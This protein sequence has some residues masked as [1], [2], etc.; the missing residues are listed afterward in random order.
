[1]LKRL[2]ETL[3][4]PPL[5]LFLLIGAGLLLCR[6]KPMLGKWVAGLSALALWCLCT[7]FVAAALLRSLQSD[8]AL[9]DPGAFEAQAIVVFL[10]DYR[11]DAAEY[12]GDSVGPLTL[13]RLRY[14]A[15]LS[16]G[17]GLPVLTSGGRPRSGAP[18]LASMASEVLE[19]EFGVTA[20]WSE[21]RAAN[22]RENA[23]FSAELLAAE[24]I[25]RV[26]LVTHAWHM[27]RSKGA[28]ARAGLT[29]FPAPTGFRAWPPLELSAFVPSARS[30]R[31]SSWALHEWVG[32]LWYA[33]L[34]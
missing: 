4:M 33:L 34:G 26:F 11:P 30:M 6:R 25:E 13:E 5:S 32:R 10:A 31:E 18:A 15:H 20:R 17:T 2:L 27:P 16:R 12:G 28:C 29:A 1:M 14:A 8:P 21:L 22:T 23:L 19:Q 9:S 24:G 7:P 3:V